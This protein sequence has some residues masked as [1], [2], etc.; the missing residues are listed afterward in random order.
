MKEYREAIRREEMMEKVKRLE[1][2]MSLNAKQ[3]IETDP[4]EEVDDYFSDTSE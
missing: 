1:Q 4:E 3:P 2:G